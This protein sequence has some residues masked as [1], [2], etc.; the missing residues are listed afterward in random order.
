[1]SQQLEVFQRVAGDLPGALSLANSA[2]LLR[3]PEITL[4]RTRQASW[5]RPG[6]CLYGASPFRDIAA[7]ALDLQPAMSL[8][9]R[10]IAIQDLQPG[11]T[12]GYGSLFT[13]PV[14]MRIGVVACG[15]ADGYPRHAMTGTPIV[16]A[17]T[18]TRLL[19]CVSMDML[20][21]DLTNLP[22]VRVGAPVSLWGV[23]GPPVEEVAQAANT[24]GYELLCALAP[25]VPVQT[26]N[27]RNV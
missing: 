2:A 14:A 13:A 21:V 1:V 16:V 9:S 11:D 8:R 22:N 23:D 6:I 4:A 24:I 3:Y 20:A 18:R 25:R 17:G 26:S 5:V 10:I 19:G 12:V 7:S 15:Y 27:V